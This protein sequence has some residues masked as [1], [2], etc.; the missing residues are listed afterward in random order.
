MEMMDV[1]ETLMEFQM[2]PNP[3]I[4]KKIQIGLEQLEQNLEEA[5]TDLIKNFEF[6]QLNSAELQKIKEYYL[7][8]KYLSRVRNNL[9]NN[10]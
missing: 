5:I 9:E 2:D 1:N 7:K 3:D 6:G 4:E 8:S 10:T